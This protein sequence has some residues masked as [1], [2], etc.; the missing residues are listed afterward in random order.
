[1][2]LALG[3]RGDEA[4]ELARQALRAF[5]QQEVVTREE[6]ARHAR[7]YPEVRPLAALGAVAAGK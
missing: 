7:D 2:Q 4:L 6:F 5:P 1:M 3:G